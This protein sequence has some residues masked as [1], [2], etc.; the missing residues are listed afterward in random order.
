MAGVHS[1]WTQFIMLMRRLPDI[2]MTT[3]IFAGTFDLLHV[4]HI[5]AIKYAKEHCDELVI[6]LQTDPTIDRGY[7]Q[8]PVQSTLERSIQLEALRDVDG[9][10]SYDTEEDLENIYK[11][12][13][14]DI[15]FI[16]ADHIGKI[17]TG[18]VYCAFAGV[19]TK[20]IPRNHSYSSTEL[21]ERVKKV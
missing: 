13:H 10:I 16:G 12:Y 1:V 21:K 17:N 7:K 4:G 11:L 2:K 8:R 9:V 3:G 15:R 5:I 14:L 6:A 20:F 18:D 19:E